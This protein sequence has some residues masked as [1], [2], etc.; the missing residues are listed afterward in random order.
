MLIRYTCIIFYPLG[1]IAWVKVKMNER[2]LHLAE[3]LA[4]V[5]VLQQI[6]YELIFS[7]LKEL[8]KCLN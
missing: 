4:E 2:K 8:F 6:N 1:I 7:A 5:R 3:L